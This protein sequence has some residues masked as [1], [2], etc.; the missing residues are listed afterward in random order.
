VS[1]KASFKKLKEIAAVLRS[2]Q[3]G[4]EEI[5]EMRQKIRK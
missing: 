3:K 4:Q 5:T 2:L 1:V